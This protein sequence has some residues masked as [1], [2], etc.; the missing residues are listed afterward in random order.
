LLEIRYHS[1]VLSLPAFPP[2]EITK[3]L[4]SELV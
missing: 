3:S 1:A 2:N 4:L